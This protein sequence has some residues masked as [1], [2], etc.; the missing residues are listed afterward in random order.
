[1]DFLNIYDK[2]YLNLNQGE[3]TQRIFLV[4]AEFQKEVTSS[5][6]W[7]RNYNIDICCFKVTPYK[8]D[9]KIF[10]DFDK[11][12]PLPETEEYQIKVAN[13]DQELSGLSESTR[14]RHGKRNAFWRKFIEYNIQN[15]GI[16]ANNKVTDENYL[17]KPIDT[18]RGAFV[19]LIIKQNGCRVEVY[20]EG[21]KDTNKRNFDALRKEEEKLKQEFPDLL[22]G[23]DQSNTKS[24]RIYLESNYRYT[25]ESDRD[26]LF[27]YFLE[28]SQKFMDVFTEMGRTLKLNQKNG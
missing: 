18:I 8:Y 3:N 26:L 19:E 23:D 20:F 2:N 15:N 21:D 14:I 12:I 7:L 13:K 27:Q 6:I 16:F 17:K 22:W 24:R 5:V 4:A 10:I 1:M 28:N 9:G 11:I 25:E